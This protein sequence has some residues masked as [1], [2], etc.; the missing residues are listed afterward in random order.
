[1]Q[2][3]V[4]LQRMD[5]STPQSTPSKP[6]EERK[7]SE[8]SGHKRKLEALGTGVVAVVRTKIAKLF[9]SSSAGSSAD[10][11]AVP[12]IECVEQH[13]A[14]YFY[15][16]ISCSGLQLETDF[17][18]A[19]EERALIEYLDS[20]TWA[21][22]LTRRVQQFGCA[23][24]FA[25]SC[26]RLNRTAPRRLVYKYNR[27]GEQKGS[28]AA[29]AASV[30]AIPAAFDALCARLVERGLFPRAPEQVIVNEYQPG[31]GIAAHVDDTKLFGEPVCSVSLLADVTMDFKHKP[32]PRKASAGAGAGAGVGAAAAGAGQPA[33]AES[34]H[35][36]RL[37]R[38]S[39]LLL[40]GAARYEWTHAIAK[41]RSD[42]DPSTGDR[43][44]RARRVSLT[45]RLLA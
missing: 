28:A 6:A 32:R 39:A 29:A 8:H 45:F 44:P 19:E 36:V 37:P 7:S 41:R 18:S 15:M 40:T 34:E 10:Q 13:F 25:S 16:D 27:A 26:H 33:S 4:K 5:V 17:V 3:L 35:S 42:P 1:L 23:L 12:A 9:S 24:L 14:W 43:V 31:Q 30:P 38:R 2:S 11:S 20:Q 21:G 22:T